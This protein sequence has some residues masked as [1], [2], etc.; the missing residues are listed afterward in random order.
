[1]PFPMIAKIARSTETPTD[2]QNKG[3]LIEWRASVL[4]QVFWSV[5]L[6]NSDI[7]IYQELDLAMRQAMLKSMLKYEFSDHLD[8]SS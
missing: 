1:M 6:S 3:A 4:L 2:V 5:L 8:I 7:L